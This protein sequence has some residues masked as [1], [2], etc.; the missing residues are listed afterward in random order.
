MIL[1]RASTQLK[2]P[3]SVWKS[4]NICASNRQ[5]LLFRR[6]SLQLSKSQKD[7]HAVWQRDQWWK[8]RSNWENENSDVRMNELKLVISAPEAE[9]SV[10]GLRESHFVCWQNGHKMNIWSKQA[11]IYQASHFGDL[12]I[13]QM[14]YPMK[15]SWR[16][17]VT[18]AAE[19][20][21]VAG[22]LLPLCSCCCTKVFALFLQLGPLPLHLGPTQNSKS[23]SAKYLG[24]LNFW[25]LWPFA[26]HHQLLHSSLF[27]P[28]VW[29]S[30]CL[31]FCLWVQTSKKQSNWSAK[32]L[33]YLQF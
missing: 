17:L 21:S 30:I 25:W 18:S 23:R 31:Q 5:R 8:F 4:G 26:S 22:L 1:S 20:S 3:N 16:S 24:Y 10:A 12:Q 28:P 29:A 33:G 9:S 15:G 19:A 13:F 11:S 14:E 27:W 7:L 2:S 6:G 32:Y